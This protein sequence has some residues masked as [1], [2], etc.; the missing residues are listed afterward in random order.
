MVTRRE[1][2]QRWRAFWNP[3]RKRDVRE[4]VRG[5]AARFGFAEDAF[6]PFFRVVEAEQPILERPGDVAIFNQMEDRFVKRH[7][8]GYWFLSYFPDTEESV[9][10]VSKEAKAIPEAFVVSRNGLAATLAAS[11][12]SEVVRISVLA[13]V[14]IL[15]V[16]FLLINNIRMALAALLPAATGVL[17][18]FAVMVLTGLSINVANMMAGIVVVGLCIDYGIFMAHGYV[19]GEQVLRPTRHAVTLSA[20]TTL[21]GAG[22]LI[23]ARHPALFS[24]GLTLVVGVFSGYLAA[25]LGVPALCAL[26]GARPAEGEER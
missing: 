10:A 13:L 7:P 14:L 9:A 3:D 21:M 19:N 20:C 15:A 22:V 6:E 17:W 11:I 8:D 5:T 4:H 18:L 26:V 12:A 1:N 2:V 16:T 23:F 25:W 24:I